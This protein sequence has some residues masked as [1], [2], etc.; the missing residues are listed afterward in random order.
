MILGNGIDLIEV[1][2]IKQTLERHG[3]RFLDRIFTEKEQHYCLLHKH[4]E[5]HLAGRFAAKEACAKALG[6]GITEHV[7]WK[8]I[9]IINNAKGKPQVVLSPSLTD[10]LQHNRL[11]IHLSISHTHS[12]AIASVIIEK[13]EG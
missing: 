13:M 2:R 3:A 4:K 11:S 7:G 5:I 12:I 6:T 10:R 8:D 9:E 1:E